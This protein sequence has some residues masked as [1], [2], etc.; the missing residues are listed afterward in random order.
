MVLFIKIIPLMVLIHLHH[1]V[2][3]V[4]IHKLF[5]IHN[6]P[7]KESTLTFHWVQLAQILLP[8]QL[9]QVLKVLETDGTDAV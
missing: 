2:K 3:R 4:Q 8:R 5:Y 1:I 7:R 6:T 9:V